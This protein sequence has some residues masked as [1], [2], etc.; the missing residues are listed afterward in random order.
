VFIISF[1][2]KTAV[3][4][5][6]KSAFPSNAEGNRKQRV[7]RRHIGNGTKTIHMPNNTVSDPVVGVVCGVD[8]FLV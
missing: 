1:F 8:F 5:N 2:S 4:S 3:M 7:Q 6:N